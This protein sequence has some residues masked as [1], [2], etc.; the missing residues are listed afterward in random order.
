MNERQAKILVEMGERVRQSQLTE[1]QNAEHHDPAR[2]LALMTGWQDERNNTPALGAKASY[3][4]RIV[5][6]RLGE[7]MTFAYWYDY[8]D[9]DDI[10]ATLDIRAL[11][12]ERETV[13]KA[14]TMGLAVLEYVSLGG[15]IDPVSA[16]QARENIIAALN[17]K[18]KEPEI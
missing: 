1:M 14:L 18:A 3:Q 2:F 13:R 11:L 5:L 17:P 8:Q 10:I 6:T 12:E 9:Y 4:D 16:Q 15:P 7:L